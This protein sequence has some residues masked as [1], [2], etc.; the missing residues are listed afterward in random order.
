VTGNKDNKSGSISS[1]IKAKY[2]DASGLSLTETWSAQN[3]LG[4]EVETKDSIA[5]GL[6]LNFLGSLAPEKGTREAK[7]LVEYKQE[8]IFTRTSL[9]LFRG[10]TIL[11][12]GV[13]GSDGFVAGAEVGYD[14]QEAKVKKYGVALGF[15]APLFSVNLLA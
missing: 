3:L 10:P 14:V 1:D 7:A 8:Y 15:I 5:K 12:D 11:A 13:V 9:D 4:L 2:T 6:K